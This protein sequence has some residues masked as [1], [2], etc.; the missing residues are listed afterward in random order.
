MNMKAFS[1][2]LMMVGVGL[3][4]AVAVSKAAEFP[5]GSPPFV[6]SYAEAIKQAKETGKPMLLV[7]SAEWCGPCQRNKNEVYPSAQVRPYHEAFVWAYLD[8]DVKANQ[9]AAEAFQVNGVPHIHFVNSA[10][11]QTL[12]MEVGSSSPRVFAKTLKRVI[13]KAKSSP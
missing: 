4:G 13:A 6:T 9:Q 8:V 11:T 10:G 2:V 12:D 1:L 5:A 3:L 7:F